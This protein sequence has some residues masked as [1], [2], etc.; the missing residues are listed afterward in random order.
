MQIYK[1]EKPLEKLGK[2]VI[3][4]VSYSLNYGVDSQ[5]LQLHIRFFL[6]FPFSPT[7]KYSILSE[8][9]IDVHKFLKLLK[10]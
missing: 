10:A 6:L 5:I 4:F 9:T 3:F 2:V 1:R 8:K 7:S